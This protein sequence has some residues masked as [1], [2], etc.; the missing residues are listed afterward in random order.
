MTSRPNARIT[1]RIPRDR[2]PVIPAFDR[3][4]WHDLTGARVLA[5]LVI[6]VAVGVPLLGLIAWLAEQ[7]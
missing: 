7:P 5:A 3:P 4:R 2:A 6:V 1:P